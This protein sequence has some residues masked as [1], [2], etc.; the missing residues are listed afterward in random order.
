MDDIEFLEALKE[1][2]ETM[3]VQAAMDHGNGESLER[4]IDEGAM[5]DVYN[6]IL[7][8]LEHLKKAK[9][10]SNGKRNGKSKVR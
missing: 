8:K 10:G 4:L 2:I 5:P 1:Y 7:E 3:E 9:R 6:E